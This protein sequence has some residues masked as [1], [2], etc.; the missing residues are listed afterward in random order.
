MQYEGGSLPLDPCASFTWGSVVDFSIN[1]SGGYTPTCPAPPVQF[2]SYINVSANDATLQWFCRIRNQWI[3]EHGLGFY[4]G[5]GTSSLELSTNV[6]I[7]GLSP[8]TTYDFYKLP[9]LWTLLYQL[10]GLTLFSRWRS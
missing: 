9:I 8:I 5:S 3:V 6:F 4:T 1:I 10:F 2:M 7:T